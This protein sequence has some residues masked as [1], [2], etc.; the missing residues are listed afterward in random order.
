MKYVE[1]HPQNVGGRGEQ[2]VK[3]EVIEEEMKK[4]VY[5][6]KAYKVPSSDGFTPAFF[7][8]FWE[9]IKIELIW[10]TRDML[11]IGKML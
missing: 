1:F 11:R 8:H 4:V 5:S 7:Q 3:R 2:C 6:I 9:V 10:A